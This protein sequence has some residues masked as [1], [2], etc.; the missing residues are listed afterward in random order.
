MSGLSVI[1]IF[2]LFLNNVAAYASMN[3]VS[4]DMLDSLAAS[5]ESSTVE[6]IGDLKEG[7]TSPSG[8]AIRDC[9]LGKAPCQRPQTDADN[10]KRV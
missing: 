4:A 9:L 7:A 8:V 1:S 5:H 3:G 10:V 6:M 2:S